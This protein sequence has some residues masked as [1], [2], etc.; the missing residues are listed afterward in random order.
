[1]TVC[2]RILMGHNQQP[3]KMTNSRESNSSSKQMTRLDHQLHLKLQLKAQTAQR[4]H[5]QVAGVA[6]AG[7][8]VV[9]GAGAAAQQAAGVT[10]EQH[11]SRGA[12]WRTRG[13]VCG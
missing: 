9:A 13:W 8:G 6:G 10:P 12:T 3:A 5:R 4:P 2:K 7:V 1:M 11:L